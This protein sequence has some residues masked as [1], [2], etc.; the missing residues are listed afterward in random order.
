ML[1]CCVL[2]S[3]AG[4]QLRVAEVPRHILM[5]QWFLG[6]VAHLI[7]AGSRHRLCCRMP[8]WTWHVGWGRYHP[9]EPLYDPD[10]PDYLEHSLG[11]LAYRNI[12]WLETFGYRKEKQICELLLT[13]EQVKEYFP[14]SRVEFLE[15]DEDNEIIDTSPEPITEEPGDDAMRIPRHRYRFRRLRRNSLML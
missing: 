1:T 12:S 9:G 6:G 7:A 4:Y 5:L 13:L 11:G 8:E 2:H 3:K 14:G 10:C 15:N